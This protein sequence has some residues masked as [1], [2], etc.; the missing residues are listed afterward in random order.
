MSKI[1]EKASNGIVL[2]NLGVLLIKAVDTPW[3]TAHF[4][5]SRRDNALPWGLHR[6]ILFRSIQR[7][8]GVG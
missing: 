8:F 5:P 6:I 4:I 1:L 3:T 7:G 2:A